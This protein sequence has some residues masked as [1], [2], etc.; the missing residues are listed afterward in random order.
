MRRTADEDV[1]RDYIVTLSVMPRPVP[2]PKRYTNT[3]KGPDFHV[4]RGDRT[5]F[6]CEVKTLCD[7]GWVGTRIDSRT[8]HNRIADDIHEAVK[9]FDSVN[10]S[11][12]VPNVLAFVNHDEMS[13]V[14]DI[15]ETVTGCI[16][17]NLGERFPIARY[18][19]LANGRIA[20]EKL[21]IGFVYVVRR[22]R[23]KE[24]AL[25][26]VRAPY[27]LSDAS[28]EGACR[29]LHMQRQIPRLEGGQPRGGG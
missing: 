23:R 28:V 3:P 12:S 15:D 17:T 24:E 1:V 2:R 8:I 9:Q 6:F 7:T 10:P 5:I 16:T 29:G 19:P 4:F 26:D 21:R 25:H 14:T 27:G 13:I 18:M 20:D 22:P 11:A